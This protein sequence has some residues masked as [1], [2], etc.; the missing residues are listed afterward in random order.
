MIVLE[1][2]RQNLNGVQGPQDWLL[3][4]F[5]HYPAALILYD[6]CCHK[7]IR[8]NAAA[9]DL[10]AYS[11]DQ[12]LSLAYEDLLETA[13]QADETHR[14]IRAN[15]TGFHASVKHVALQLDGHD[16]TAAIIEDRTI[17]VQTRESLHSSLWRLERAQQI[18]LS[19]CWDWNIPENTIRLSQ[20]AFRILELPVPDA[21][22]GIIEFDLF[23]SRVYPE[24]RSRLLKA[25]GEALTHARSFKVRYRIEQAN[26]IIRHVKT[27]C[28]LT[29]G[30]AGIPVGVFGTIQD[31][32][33][34]TLSAK[35]LD[36]SRE[37][38][39]RLTAHLQDIREEERRR[40]A[41]ELH[42]QLGQ[43]LTVL[44]MGISWAEEQL[45][46]QDKVSSRLSELKTIAEMTVETVRGIISDLRPPELDDLG[47]LAALERM[48][49]E[50]HKSCETRFSLHTNK[51]HCQL[52]DQISTALFRL[53]QEACT[54]IVKHAAAQKAEIELIYHED[55]ITLQVRD[56]GIGIRCGRLDGQQEGG[57]G[58]LG[59]HERVQQ[60][61]GI[62]LVEAME[63]GGTLVDIV[64]PFHMNG[65]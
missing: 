6:N 55:C 47:L 7:I 46:E 2:D 18:S 11:H 17:V 43:T 40:I 51:P 22:E 25:I 59:M 5:D 21:P 34:M 32:T 10:Y 31:V 42:D 13:S 19:G 33:Q 12:F 38:L 60:L 54:N 41:R 16:V 4:L 15:G 63:T 39:H 57:M 44:R 37:K 26:G 48:T 27:V 29:T 24:D 45:P 35:R 8:A 65:R 52:P 23:L 3:S 58:L 14:H 1:A 53:V 64:V 20:Q 61:S 30:D 9:L 50:F 49:L 62:I 28:Q 36:A 56:D